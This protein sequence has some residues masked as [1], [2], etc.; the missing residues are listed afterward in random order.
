MPA[1]DFPHAPELQL[2]VTP[3]AVG[4]VLALMEKQDPRPGGLRVAVQ[5]GGG[6][7]FQYRFDFAEGPGR[8]DRV[9]PCGEFDL[10]VDDIS[11]GYIDGSELDYVSTLMTEGFQVNNPNA[12]GMCG[13]GLSVSF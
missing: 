13:C 2:T 11:A 7:G 10:I 12:T 3:N 5:G 8:F 9:V 1:T 6:S 4:R